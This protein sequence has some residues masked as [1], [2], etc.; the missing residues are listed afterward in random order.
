MKI[1]MSKFMLLF[2]SSNFPKFQTSWYECCPCK[3]ETSY[4]AIQRLPVVLDISLLTKTMR[5]SSYNFNKAWVRCHHLILM[6]N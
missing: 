6:S 3:N 2:Y 5:K 1:R 4:A